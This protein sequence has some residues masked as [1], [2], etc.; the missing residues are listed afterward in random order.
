VNVEQVTA[1]ETEAELWEFNRAV[2]H[3]AAARREPVR[4]RTYREVLLAYDGT[5]DARAAL[6]RVATV[7]SPGTHVTVIA[8]IPYEAVGSRLDPIKPE[9]REW[10]WNCLV[11]ATAYLRAVGIDPFIEAAA[12]NPATV[13]RETAQ[14]LEA[15]LVVLGG[16]RPR[17]WRPSI[18]QHRVRPTLQRQLTCDTLVVRDGEWATPRA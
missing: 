11:E 10:Q 16:G 15:D 18:K 14:S 5:P 2:E 8:V 7:A 1:P 3:A 13:I 6:E 9:Q 4:R 17:G 12:G